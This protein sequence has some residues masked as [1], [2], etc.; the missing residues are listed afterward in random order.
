MVITGAMVS[1]GIR[2]IYGFPTGTVEPSQADFDSLMKSYPHGST[3]TLASLTTSQQGS[4]NFL[5]R[6]GFVQFGETKR[7]R[8]TPNGNMIVLMIRTEDGS[9]SRAE[10]PVSG[11]Y[12][13][14]REVGKKQR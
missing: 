10:I 5:K 1:C 11:F 4:I 8:R 3:W 9:N 13:K 14:K 6:N 2:Q 12:K 7:N